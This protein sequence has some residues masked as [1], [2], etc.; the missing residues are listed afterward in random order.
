MKNKQLSQSVLINKEFIRNG[1]ETP[2]KII[3]HRNNNIDLT[4]KK[5]FF[6]FFSLILKIYK[7]NLLN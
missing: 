3:Q 2:Q 5:L 1:Y 6:I 7:F 4:P